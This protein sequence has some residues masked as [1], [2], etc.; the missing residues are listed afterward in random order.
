VGV[1]R[2]VVVGSSRPEAGESGRPDQGW[3]WRQART[4]GAACAGAWAAPCL[5]VSP[6]IQSQARRCAAEMSVVSWPGGRQLR[7]TV[8]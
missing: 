2:P 3:E 7:A 6:A 8:K 1:G 5:L 4:F